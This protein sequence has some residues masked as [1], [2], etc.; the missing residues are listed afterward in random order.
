MVYALWPESP[1]LVLVA[2]DRTRLEA[3]AK[4]FEDENMITLFVPIGHNF[5]GGK[6]GRWVKLCYPQVMDWVAKSGVVEALR[7]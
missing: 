7:T 4:N 2:R 5:F 3:E 6:I 1:K